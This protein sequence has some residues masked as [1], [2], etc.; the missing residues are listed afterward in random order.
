MKEKSLLAEFDVFSDPPAISGG[1]GRE[2]SGS[3]GGRPV[4]S[5]P[6]PEPPPTFEELR[7]DATS[8]VGRGNYTADVD[9]PDD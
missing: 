7:I 8:P 5:S 9:A 2:A 4:V 1:S 6:A 3:G